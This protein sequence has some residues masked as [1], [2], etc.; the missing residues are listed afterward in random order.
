[1]SHPFGVTHPTK[2]Q[3]FLQLLHQYFYADVN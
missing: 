2:M 3:Q 1:V